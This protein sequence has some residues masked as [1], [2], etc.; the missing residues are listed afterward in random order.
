MTTIEQE[1]G[2]YTGRVLLVGACSSEPLPLTPYAATHG[3]AVH[4]T[5]CF[6]LPSADLGKSPSLRTTET[7]TTYV[8]IHLR[9]FAFGQASGRFPMALAVAPTKSGGGNL[10]NLLDVGIVFACSMDRRYI[11]LRGGFRWH[12]CRLNSFKKLPSP[13]QVKSV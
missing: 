8:S 10:R 9:S 12:L 13:R 2:C 5:T 3:C 6:G 7:K 11:E 4:L 1:P